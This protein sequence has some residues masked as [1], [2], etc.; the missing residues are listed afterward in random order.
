MAK[1]T[2]K[3]E[4]L[5]VVEDE[6]TLTYSADTLTLNTFADI[7]AGAAVGTR[8]PFT[9]GVLGEWGHGKTS[10]LRQAKS[11]IDGEQ[12]PSK[13]AASPLFDHPNIVT[14]WFNAWQY[15]H[16]EHPLVPLVTAIYREVTARS[17]IDFK[18]RNGFTA[19]A[20]NA[21]KSGLAKIGQ[22][23]EAIVAST[24]LSI[25]GGLV[26]PLTG[27]ALQAA[28]AEPVK[29]QLS[30]SGAKAV[31]HYRAMRD[32][33]EKRQNKLLRQQTVYQLAFQLL[34]EAAATDAKATQQPKVVVFIDDLDRCSPPSAIRLLEHLK[35]VFAQPG[36]VFVLG[37]DDQIL[38]DH[39]KSRYEEDYRVPGHRKAGE[40]YLD[41]IIQLAID[42][43][44]HEQQFTDHISQIMAQVD[45]RRTELELTQ[46][47]LPID[48]G[49]REDFFRLL[50]AGCAGNPRQLVRNLNNL[51]VDLRLARAKPDLIGAAEG[52]VTE[53]KFLRFDVIYLAVRQALGRDDARRLAEADDLCQSLQQDAAQALVPTT[54]EESEGPQPFQIDKRLR[55]KHSLSQ[56]LR[57]EPELVELLKHYGQEWLADATGRHAVVSFLVEQRRDEPQT[58]SEAPPQ[59]PQ[60]DEEHFYAA[61]RKSLGLSAALR[62]ATTHS[63][64]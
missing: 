27:V 42:L 37:V 20:W 15:E 14:V 38:R 12:Q 28:G 50:A 16:E 35:L 51:I 33:L 24:D 60:T 53:E 54:E 46:D 57:K 18:A 13:K 9:I 6:P 17:K 2:S 30:V 58:S 7:V 22:A 52:Q 3:L 47:P 39:L 26:D 56:R 44:N 19:K 43:P 48:P 40:R 5:L 31:E 11:R 49:R 55:D 61:V 59:Q 25:E 62:S 63:A 64:G 36:F 4:P 23:M 8:G 29:G 10:V 41:K 32:D 1:A 21:T 45:R 34:G